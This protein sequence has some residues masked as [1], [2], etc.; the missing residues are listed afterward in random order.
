MHFWPAT[1][2]WRASERAEVQTTEDY[3]SAD[4][5]ILCRHSRES[6]NPVAFAAATT[7]GS[8]FRGNDANFAQAVT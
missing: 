6:G 1:L 3:E 2:Q 4:T 7:L 8:R 5:R